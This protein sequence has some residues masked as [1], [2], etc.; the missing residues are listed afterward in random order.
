MVV[1]LLVLIAL[2]SALSSDAAGAPRVK[3]I[4]LAGRTRIEYVEQGD[5]SGVPVVLLHG[6]SDSWRSYDLVLP[7]LPSSMRVFSLSQRGHGDSGRPDRGYRTEDFAADVRAFMDAL[8]LDRAVIVGHSMGGTIAQRVAIDNPRR[9]LALVLVNTFAT[10]RDNPSVTEFW[11]STIS[12][13]A[14]PV[15]A[16]FIRDFQASTLAQPVQT[17]YFERIVGESRK[18]PA[19]VWKDVFEGFLATDLTPARSRIAVPTLIVWGGQDAYSPRSEQDVLQTAIRGA[20]L[21]VYPAAGHALHWEEPRRFA[22]DL[23]AFVDRV[24]GTRRG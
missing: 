21:V 4:E 19:R 23:A 24:A 2:A 3:S 13:L 9:V 16:A 8:D 14:D 5:P 10:Y 7:H 22:S 12:K 15:D 18:L 1:V 11:D 17:A 6:Y 20:E